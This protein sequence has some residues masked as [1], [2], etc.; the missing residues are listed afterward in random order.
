MRTKRLGLVMGLLV[1]P[2]AIGCCRWCDHWCPQR[3]DYAAPACTPCCLAPAPCCPA[4]AYTPPN[5]CCPTPPPPPVVAH[6]Q[7]PP[8]PSPQ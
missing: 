4:P 6:Y 2:G 1:L 8:P 7:S 3:H 5:N